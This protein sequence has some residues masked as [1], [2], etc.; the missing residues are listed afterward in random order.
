MSER[1][2]SGKAREQG[3]AKEEVRVGG[4]GVLG[5]AFPTNLIPVLPHFIPSSTFL[6]V[7]F[8]NSSNIQND[9]PIAK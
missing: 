4:N 3:F 5:K 8:Q 9:K 6:S 2:V 7:P 1:A